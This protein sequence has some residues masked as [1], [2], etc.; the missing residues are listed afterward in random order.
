M[1][2]TGLTDLISYF[3]SSPPIQ[4]KNCILH[5]HQAIQ[6]SFDRATEL[7]EL[8]KES[9]GTMRNN[10][11]PWGSMISCDGSV[12]K[13]KHLIWKQ[14]IACQTPVRNISIIN[15]VGK[16]FSKKQVFCKLQYFEATLLCSVVFV[17]MKWS[18]MNSLW[19][20]DRLFVVNPFLWSSVI[21]LHFTASFWF[22]VS[23]MF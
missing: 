4:K 1:S 22:P 7:Y 12:C 6:C 14:A 16:L 15:M 23:P 8:W 19:C 3:K 2:W 21:L 5:Q 13:L 17:K 20:L 11:E 9:W 18:F 10:A